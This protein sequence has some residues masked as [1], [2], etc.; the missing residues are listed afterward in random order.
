MYGLYQIVVFTIIDILNTLK[1]PFFIG[2]VF[3]IY[4]QY[5]KIGQMEKEIRGYRRNTFLKLFRSI[6]FGILGGIITTVLFLYL[7]VV[8]IPKDFMYI[9]GAAIGLSFINPRYMCFAY[10]GGIISLLS[11]TISF[12]K[13]QISQVM[14]VVAVLH[15]VESVLIFLDGAKDKLPFFFQGEKEI[16]GGFNMNRFWPIPFVVFMGDGLIQP[17][18]LMAILSYGDYSISSYPRRKTMNTSI[19]LFIYSIILLYISKMMINPFIPPI[20]AILGH[21]YIILRNK[22]KENRGFHIFSPPNKGVKILETLPNSIGQELGIGMGDIV[23]KINEID[24]NNVKDL[25]DI[26]ILEPTSMRI[27]LFNIKSGLIT[28][29][30]N[31]KG[32]PLGLVIVPRGF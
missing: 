9:L 3:I 12:P 6:I 10:G 21:E 8:V 7:G 17:I 1:S 29:K 2:I 16:H 15:M 5:Y 24:V 28:K 14:S 27:E 26:M 11:L 30:Y 4:L 13:I 32:K 19:I 22:K 20:F 18:T 31:G 23:L 25:E